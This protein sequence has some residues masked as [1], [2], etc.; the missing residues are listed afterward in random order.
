MNEIEKNNKLIKNNYSYLSN[1]GSDHSEIFFYDWRDLPIKKGEFKTYL[2][3]KDNELEESKHEY[4][5]ESGHG[6]YIELFSKNSSENLPIE[7]RIIN[8]NGLH[9]FNS[10]STS[11][12]D[13]KGIPNIDKLFI[14]EGYER[15]SYEKFD[16]IKITS[17]VM[18]FM[19]Y[20][21]IELRNSKDEIIILQDN[22]ILREEGENYGQYYNCHNGTYDVYHCDAIKDKKVLK[23][24]DVQIVF[25]CCSSSV[26]YNKDLIVKRWGVTNAYCKKCDKHHNNPDD[27]ISRKDGK[28]IDYNFEALDG[29][30]NLTDKKEYGYVFRLRDKNTTDIKLDFMKNE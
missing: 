5:F 23:N 4:Y 3:L 21:D 26:E 7:F 18:V 11:D 16:S 19:Q 9:M 14:D 8:P 25:P 29:R 27:L 15:F 22:Q 6:L 17:N 24:S 20:W 28:K 10:L 1:F 30:G 2:D 12:W 13:K